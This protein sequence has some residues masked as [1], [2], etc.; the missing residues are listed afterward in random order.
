MAPMKAQHTSVFT[1]AATAV[2]WIA[3]ATVVLG[4]VALGNAIAR[5][6]QTTP[7]SIDA[8]NAIGLDTIVLV[9]VSLFVS[10]L[11][12]FLGQRIRKESLTALYLAIALLGLVYIP[13]IIIGL[14][15]PAA[16]WIAVGIRAYILIRLGQPLI[17]A[18]V[19]MRP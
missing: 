1:T 6:Q 17:Q 2:V 7:V 14:I 15:Q 18:I 5:V 12:F 13:G 16:D 4:L 10:V 8:A 9:T 11:F 3:I 19:P